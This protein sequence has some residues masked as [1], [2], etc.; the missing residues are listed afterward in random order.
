MRSDFLNYTT[1]YISNVMSL[2]KPQKKSL[3]VLHEIASNVNLQK[4]MD[5]QEALST[6]N[7]L[8]PTCTN[9]E[10]DFMSLTFALATGVG[11]TRLMGAFIAYLYTNHNIKNFFVVAP[12]TTIYDKLQRDL[13]DPNS[14]KYVFKGLSCFVNASQ[15]ITGEDYRNKPLISPKNLMNSKMQFTK[16]QVSSVLNK[17]MLRLIYFRQQS[18]MLCIK[19]L[20]VLYL[21]RLQRIQLRK[22]LK[23]H[24]KQHL[25][26]QILRK[27]SMITPSSLLFAK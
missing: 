1:D 15:I 18:M 21:R 27:F 10:R 5:L 23:K 26:N 7:T 6:V 25:N 2:R 13:G 19:V 22:L 3:E 24:L 8:F 14:A 9:F 11:K 17:Q 12:G 16:R 20:A 4:G